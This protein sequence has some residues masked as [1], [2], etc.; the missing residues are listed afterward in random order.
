VLVFGETRMGW[1]GEGV[2]YGILKQRKGEGKNNE[3]GGGDRGG[4][5]NL[6]RTKSKGKKNCREGRSDV[7]MSI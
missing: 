4:R 5:K 3:G 6:C 7:I 2:R 1:R